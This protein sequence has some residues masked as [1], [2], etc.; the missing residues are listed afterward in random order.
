M[1]AADDDPLFLQIKEAGPSVLETYLEKSTYANHGQRVVVGQ[2]LMQAASDLFLGW[3]EGQAGRHFYVRQLRD[4]KIK[5]LVE[6][7]N[8]STMFD[9]AMFCGWTLARA[10]ARSGDPTMIAGYMGKSDVFDK[11]MATF[12]K[13]YAEQVEQDHADFKSA[14][15]EG[16]IEVQNED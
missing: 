15:R 5:P 3:T 16:R 12:S 9:Y 2:H 11:A 13:L 6:I 14:I 10:H 1:M 8:P 4:M 7:F